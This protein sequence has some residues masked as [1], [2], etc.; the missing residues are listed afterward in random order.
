MPTR[1]RMMKKFLIKNSV[2]YNEFI[3][4]IDSQPPTLAYVLVPY[5][6]FLSKLNI[7]IPSKEDAIWKLIDFHTWR[8]INNDFVV[9]DSLYWLYEDVFDFV[10]VLGEAYGIDSLLFSY[11]QYEEILGPGAISKWEKDVVNKAKNWRTKYL[12]E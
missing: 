4:I 10:E 6:K 1:S 11:Y 12:D 2:F 7:A 5:K 8:I 9:F 3:D